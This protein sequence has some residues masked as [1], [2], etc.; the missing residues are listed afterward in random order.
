MIITICKETN[1]HKSMVTIWE[2][3]IDLINII[4]I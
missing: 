2:I 4:K 3:L 1:I